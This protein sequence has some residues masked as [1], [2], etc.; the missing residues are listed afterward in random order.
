MGAIWVRHLNR[1][2]FAPKQPVITCFLCSL[3]HTPS[4]GTAWQLF[5]WGSNTTTLAEAKGS[6]QVSG[7][8]STYKF[9]SDD[10]RSD[11]YVSVHTKML[12][13]FKL[14]SYSFK[15]VQVEVITIN[16]PCSSK[17]WRVILGPRSSASQPHRHL[18]CNCS[19]SSRFIPLSCDGSVS[20]F[21]SEFG[22][23]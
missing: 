1:M 14:A 6:G 18:R 7:G 11:W 8:M 16:I 2:P 13:L 9:K 4:M 3:V 22:Q 19:S 17:R 20:P 10:F 5:T 21:V 23:M 15:L 12:H